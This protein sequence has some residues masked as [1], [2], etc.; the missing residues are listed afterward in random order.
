MDSSNNIE[1]FTD[2]IPLMKPWLGEEE[3]DAAK[4]V[5]LS[6]WVSQGPM[7]Q[8]FEKKVASYVQAKFGVATNACTNALLMALR[9]SG[10]KSGNGVLLP[11]LTCMADA[12]AILALDAKPQFVDIDLP[13]FNMDPVHAEK[14]IDDTTK[15]I[16][17]VHQIGLPADI[18]AFKTLAAKYNLIFIEDAACALGAKYKGIPLGG[19]GNPAAFSFHPRKMTTTGEGGMLV[20][21]DDALIEKARQLRSTGAS[22]SDLVRHKAKGIIQQVYEDYGYNFRMTDI[23]AAIGIVQ[24]GKLTD[25]IKQRYQQAKFYDQAFKNNEIVLPPYVP[26][27]T[28]HA[29]SSYCVRLKNFN[30]EMITYILKFMAD[31]NISCRRGIQPLHYEPFFKEAHGNLTLPNTEKAAN[32][33]LFLPIF[34]GLT[35]LQQ[36]RI[37][38]TLSESIISVQKG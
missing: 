7:V 20:S 11:S 17:L 32:E 19:H 1:L 22:V 6:G 21:D 24:M 9:I 13:T 10:I 8:A 16:L 15:A 31:H 3:G 34:P 38:E 23:Q 5:I 33:S 29:Y 30:Y 26:P 28:H 4:K 36:A 14:V 27:N 18:D 2:H 12:N 25:I 37:I 35:R